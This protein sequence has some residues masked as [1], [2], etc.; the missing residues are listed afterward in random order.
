MP[1]GKIFA[2]YFAA[3]F[4]FVFT[5][6]T[7][8]ALPPPSF[9]LP[10]AVTEKPQPN[11]LAGPS[12]YVPD[13]FETAPD[14]SPPPAAGNIRLRAMRVAGSAADYFDVEISVNAAAVRRNATLVFAYTPVRDYVPDENSIGVTS[15]YQK[16]FSYRISELN[17]IAEHAEHSVYSVR[18]P[19]AFPNT[20]YVY[21]MLK[22]EANQQTAILNDAVSRSS[23]PGTEIISDPSTIRPESDRLVL[24]NAEVRNLSSESRRFDIV[25]TVPAAS[26][27][28]DVDAIIAISAEPNL[29]VHE[30]N[31]DSLA[32]LTQN[33]YRLRSLSRIEWDSAQS[34]YS[35]GLSVR[36]P[37]VYYAYIM[38]R[39]GA[40]T[41]RIA[42]LTIYMPE[43][44]PTP[45]PTPVPSP[46]PT[47][48]PA[49][50]PTATPTP[51]PTAIPL[52]TP[53]PPENTDAGLLVSVSGTQISAAVPMSSGYASYA[54]LSAT[55]GT[56]TSSAAISVA[57]GSSVTVNI[58][59]T[60]GASAR[61]VVNTNNI[62]PAE[63]AFEPLAALPISITVA[64]AAR[65][66]L[67]IKARAQSGAVVY[68][69]IVIDWISP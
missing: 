8:Y 52:P 17:F 59:G 64:G 2:F 25:L 12:G 57:T 46:V 23:G 24:I 6:Q 11:F 16:S 13:N 69:K 42:R 26:D 55:S 45:L 38:L 1:K 10:P 50:S 3:L 21:A 30:N 5:A 49:P 14:V 37:G 66:Y 61:C 67:W 54:L 43:P 33:H 39:S 29:F 40:T 41:S 9:S 47:A 15:N 27:R 56:A 28:S 51:T 4:A 58:A 34:V 68:Y 62:V 36:Q 35:A 63:T 65:S 18:V 31:I 20:Y 48:T 60:L 7:V 53:G 22:A 19:A 32:G 44:R